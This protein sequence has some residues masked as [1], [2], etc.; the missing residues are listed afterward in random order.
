MHRAN[1]VK[2]KGYQSTYDAMLGMY[3][4]EPLNALR[5]RHGLKRWTRDDLRELVSGRTGTVINS[6]PRALVPQSTD[7]AQ[8]V[9]I[10]P[11]LAADYL[12]PGWDPQSACPQTS[13]FLAHSHKPVVITFGSM[14]HNLWNSH[15][16]R[17]LFTALQKAQ[18]S[19][20]IILNSGC[21]LGVHQL[22]RFWDS[23]LIT[24]AGSSQIRVLCTT[25]KPPYA[26]LLPQTRA[27]ICHGGAGTT[28]A[29]LRAGVPVVVLP[30]LCDQYFWGTLVE[31]L[32][33]GAMTGALSGV[34]STELAKAVETALNEEVQHRVNRFRDDMRAEGDGGAAAAKI[35]KTIFE[36]ACNS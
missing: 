32:G 21:D 28:F 10:V 36:Q 33:L 14:A 17:V 24:W 34:A 30:V 31:Q 29:A 13:A 4:M 19:D 2:D 15:H 9:H 25:E 16:T 5:E 18:V 35:V 3:A 26:W 12:P 27:V 6:Y 1:Q 11:P 7:H 22:W 8:N 20:V 23:D